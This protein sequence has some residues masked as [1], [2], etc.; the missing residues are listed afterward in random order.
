MAAPKPG[1]GPVSQLDS[2]VALIQSFDWAAGREGKGKAITETVSLAPLVCVA[3]K[4]SEGSE[5]S[6]LTR[7]HASAP[8]TARLPDRQQREGARERSRRDETM[9]NQSFSPT[10]SCSCGRTCSFI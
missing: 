8:I 1:A 2:K 9:S 7:I 6:D 10:S 4:T 3:I 5:G